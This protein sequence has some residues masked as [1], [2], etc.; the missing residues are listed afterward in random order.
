MN[1][2]YATF[3]TK[4]NHYI[5]VLWGKNFDEAAASLFVSGLRE[6]GLLVK[7]VGL[8]GPQAA[9]SYGLVLV[10]D[11]PLSKALRLADKTV[12]IIVPCASPRWTRIQN[13][14]R[15]GEL[16]DQTQ[17]NHGKF[18]LGTRAEPPTVNG[19]STASKPHLA[20]C[21]ESAMVY[22]ENSALP[23]FVR[24]LVNILAT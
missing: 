7:V 12:C 14:P 10:T 24:D 16:F 1:L 20:F 17:A 2:L 11:M 19:T 22:P 13:D 23:D 6:A 4:N 8:D 18:V 3:M 5:F 21:R 9:G 15:V